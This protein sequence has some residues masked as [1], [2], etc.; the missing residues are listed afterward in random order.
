[1]L[2]N[3]NIALVIV[4]S[5]ISCGIYAIYWLYVTSEALENEGHAGGLSPA[6]ILVLALL[7]SPVGYCLFGM[8]SDQNLNNIKMQRG[9][10]S[11]DN[12]VLYIV[13]GVLI[14]VVLVALVQNEINKITPEY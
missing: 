14:P 11:E 9:L 1:M 7:V 5:L 8:Y 13:L 12:K 6:L 2:Q 4:F 10:P 3:R